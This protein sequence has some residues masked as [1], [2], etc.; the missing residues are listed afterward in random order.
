VLDCPDWKIIPWEN[1]VGQGEILPMIDSAAEA[2]SALSVL[3]RG[4]SG[5]VLRSVDAVEIESVAAVVLRESPTVDLVPSV[6]TA[7]A[8][9]GSGDRAC[10]DVAGLFRRSE[11]LLVGDRAAGLF[12]VASE[13]VENEF[14]DT[15]PF[16]VNA[17]GVHHYV[18]LPEGRTA[19]LSELAGGRSIL[20]VDSTGRTRGLPVGRV[21]IE[22]RPLVR[23]VVGTQSGEM[24]VT[25]Q[26]AETVHL[27]AQKG[28]CLA[29]TD[30]KPGDE[31]LVH[32]AESARHLGKSVDEWVL[33]R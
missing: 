27:M 12:L 23:V 6:V 21:K 5:V 24:S 32:I 7:V 16:R 33:E 26:H 18:L 13:T 22:H 29:V 8:L 31:V 19:Y 14:V 11:G 9:V 10:V 17:G 28:R 2:Q 1:L 3:E 20:A 4:L 15:R 30:L 25:L